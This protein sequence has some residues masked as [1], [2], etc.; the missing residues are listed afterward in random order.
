MSRSGQGKIPWASKAPLANSKNL[1]NKKFF[2]I[3][4]LTK[5]VKTHTAN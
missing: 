1:T 3:I 5:E 2:V 4:L